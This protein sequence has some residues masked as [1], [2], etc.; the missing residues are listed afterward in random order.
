M[1][2]KTRLRLLLAIIFFLPLAA[3]A[4]RGGEAP[5]AAIPQQIISLGPALTEELILL[6]AGDKIVGVTTYCVLP[7][8][9]QKIE[10]VG[11][12]TNFDL[13]RV[14][15]LRP[16][17]VLASSLTNRAQVEKLADLGIRVEP[18]PYYKNYQQI[19]AEA[20]LSGGKKRRRRLSGLRESG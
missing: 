5:G 14:V 19:C 7:A 12:V 4:A 15:A 20:Q 17:V 10:R 3:D 11:T 8:D 9:L 1:K 16:D 6:G 13:E 2:R 18:F